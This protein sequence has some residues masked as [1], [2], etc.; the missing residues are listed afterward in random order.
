VAAPWRRRIHAI[1]SKWR[2]P[3]LSYKFMKN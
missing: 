1:N 3:T 2:T